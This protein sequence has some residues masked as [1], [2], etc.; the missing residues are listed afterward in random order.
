MTSGTISIHKLG[1]QGVKGDT[2]SKGD[3]GDKGDKGDT[4]DTGPANELTIGTVTEGAADATITGTAPSQILNLTIP[5]GDT[6][7]SGADGWTPVLAVVADGDRYV[8]QVVDWVGGTGTKPAT[9]DYVGPTGLVASIGSAVNIRGAA[10]D[11]TGDV[12]GPGSSTD[13][14]MVLFDG[15]TGKAIKGGGAPFDGDY[16][17]LSN[18]PSLGAVA[19]SNDYD[20]LDNK[21]TLGTAAAADTVDFATAAQ[22]GLADSAVQPGDLAA[23]ATTGDYNDLTSAPSIPSGTVESVAITVPTGLAVSG[24]PVTATG[25]FAVTWDTGYQGYTTDEAS[26]LSGIEAGADVTDATNVTAAGAIMDGDFGSNGLMARTSSGTYTSRAVTAGT[27]IS[28]SNGTGQ[29]GNP[30]ISVSFGT[31]SSTAAVGNDSRF[32][33]SAISTK[34]A[35]YTFALADA[36]TTIYMNSSS[37]RTL[38]VPP[39]SSV[40]F[41][42]GT[43]INVGR[44]GSGSVTLTPG[45]SVTIRNAN[46]LALAS[47]YSIGTLH[48]INTNE[49]VA[50]GDLTT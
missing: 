28:V 26:K 47:R 38:T 49:W 23:V 22:G 46:G 5:K 50:G 45:S 24:S 11:G 9:G 35:N 44:L 8:Q 37:T 12:T 18:K 6:G 29:S 32:T 2:G 39:N 1:V 43:Y 31:T 40:A 10:G 42:I 17:S 33:Q 41:P 3:Q 48:K 34:T 27:A 13:S 30:T 25:T 36:G 7:A 21:P 15:T 16:G 19:T 4:G 20:D 14:E